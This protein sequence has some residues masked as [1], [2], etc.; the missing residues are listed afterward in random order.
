M[1]CEFSVQIPWSFVGEKWQ[2]GVH[3]CGPLPTFLPEQRVIGNLLATPTHVAV[4]RR[5]IAATYQGV[6]FTHFAKAK[7]FLLFLDRDFEEKN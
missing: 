5:Q 1:S 6:S 7:N 3:L 2:Q 4:T